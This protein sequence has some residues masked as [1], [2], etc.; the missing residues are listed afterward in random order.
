LVLSFAAVLDAAWLDQL[1]VTPHLFTW[2][3]AAGFAAATLMAWRGR[4]PAP[5]AR[6]ATVSAT[7]AR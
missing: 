6:V 2:L 1:N 3:L 4:A 7:P 5:F